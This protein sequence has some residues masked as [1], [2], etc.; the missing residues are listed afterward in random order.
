MSQISYRLGRAGARLVSTVISDSITTPQPIAAPSQCS[1]SDTSFAECLPHSEST[2]FLPRQVTIEK[3]SDKVLLEI[4]CDFLVASPQHWPT[5]VHICRKWRRIVFASQRALQL[6][7]FC[8][9]RTVLKTLDCWPA[10][11]IVVQHGESPVPDPPVPEVENNI[12]AALKHFDRVSSIS[13]TVT[14]SLSEKLAEIERPF[15]ELEDLVLLSR[16]GVPL[17]LP[18][19]FQWGPRLRYL[20]LTR[21]T[22]P[23]LIQLLDSSKDLVDLHLHDVLDPSR[24]PPEALTNTFSGMVQ[25]Q[26][27]SLHFISTANQLTSPPPS[28]ELVVLPTLTRLNLQGTTEYVEQLVAR[29]DT[30]LLGDIEVTFVEK[31]N[32]DLSQL[33]KFI[34]RI[35]MHKS[36]RRVDIL[37]SEHA[38]SISLTRPGYP[39]RLKFQS[40]REPVSEQLFIM[41]RIFYQFSAFL[42]NVED[43]RICAQRRPS[44][45]DALYIERWLDY[46]NSFIGVK[47]LHVSGNLSNKIVQSLQLRDGQLKSV[48]PALQKLSISQPWPRHTLLRE[49]VVTLLVSSRLSR[50]PLVVEYEQQCHINELGGTGTMH[51][52]R[53]HHCS[54]TCG[55]GP[56]SQQVTFETLSDDIL[57]NIF[58]RCLDGNS[59]NWPTLTWV[60]RRWR[61]TVLTSPLGLNLQL[62][63]TYGKP[64]LKNLDCWPALPITVKYGGVPNSYPPA[65]EDDD[66]IIAALKQ[67]ARVSSISLTVT[68]SLLN[69]LP[70]ISEPFSEL[71]ELTLLSRDTMQLTL[72]STFQWGRRLRR[73][74]S[75]RISFHS[76]L[77]LLSPCHELVNLQLHEIPSTGYSPEAFANSLSEMTQ[78]QSLSL[79]FL[80][81]PHR[82]YFGLPPPSD[83]RIVLPALTCLKYQGTSKYMDSFVARIDAPHLEDISITFFD[84]TTMDA[85]QLGRFIERI[86]MQ[87]PLV[88]A[89]IETFAN[90]IV[91]SFTN[92][93]TSAHVRLQISCERLAWQLSCMT[94]LC[95]QISPFLFHVNDLGI[96]TNRSSGWW[97]DVNG[98]QWLGLVHSFRNANSFRLVGKLTPDILYALGLNGGGTSVLPSLSHL[99]VQKPIVMHGPSWD[100]IQS[101][102][103]SRS[104]SGRLVQVDAPSY[105][106][107][108]C[109]LS[110]GEQQ[111]LKRHLRDSHKYQILCSYCG[112][113]K[114]TPGNNDLFRE[115]LVSKHPEVARTDALT[116]DSSETPLSRS[117]KHSP[118]DILFDRHSSPRAP[119]I[120]TRSTTTTAAPRRAPR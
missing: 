110:S 70:A 9:H 79:H 2:T 15:S 21:I 99:R 119:D 18:V 1:S 89:D 22:F 38:I 48:L 13:L 45:G 44:Q 55:V 37:S 114:C 40:L 73:L 20:H 5:L 36:P 95:D 80:S 35:G 118:L 51:G 102:I 108:I 84:R 53:R 104:I 81:L 93:S 111:G 65:P 64:V 10:L 7:L 76:F 69:K 4:F 97:D 28:R 58:R 17:T 90:A 41:A 34:T 72:P 19:T 25:L 105:Q 59:Q 3:L 56:F 103:T 94:Q 112:D 43:L 116:S 29:I 109:R 63:C 117:P 85:S 66:N 87:M 52:Q 77:P 57:L 61:Q 120:D 47:W 100:A 11:P 23:A 46:I 68:S 106:C 62:Y 78:L 14:S 49:A 113:F 88:Q 115:H 96:K 6:R 27:L 42:F 39:T 71:E 82:S 75:T 98:E 107:H 54:L 31:S 33:C 67:S 60:C 74:H 86:E 50:H 83:E 101:F 92:S 24:F 12:I 16:K 26:S 91:I 32:F 30:P 8:T